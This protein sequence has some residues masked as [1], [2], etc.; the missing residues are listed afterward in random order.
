MSLC[1]HDTVG[2]ICE[3]YKTAVHHEIVGKQKGDKLHEG[4]LHANCRNRILQFSLLYVN[5]SVL[6]EFLLF[7][8]SV[9]SFLFLESYTYVI[10]GY[11]AAIVCISFY[12]GGR[13]TKLQFR[14]CIPGTVVVCN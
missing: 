8:I 5:H 2:S 13:Q 11:I 1:S 6:Y 3:E 10:N 4:V 9:V 7:L 14:I 12:C